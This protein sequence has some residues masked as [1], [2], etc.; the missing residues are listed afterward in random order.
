M[1]FVSAPHRLLPILSSLVLLAPAAEAKS[2]EAILQEMVRALVATMGTAEKSVPVSMAGSFEATLV[3]ESLGP[4]PIQ[5]SATYKSRP[6]AD[7]AADLTSTVGSYRVRTN[8]RQ[9]IFEATGDARYYQGEPAEQLGVT[10]SSG[11]QHKDLE[12]TLLEMLSAVRVESVS[13]VSG[14]PSGKAWKLDLRPVDPAEAAGVERFDLYVLQKSAMPWKLNAFVDG[15]TQRADVALD[16][17][18]DLPSGMR[19]KISDPEEP[20]DARFA[21]S[22]DSKGRF[23]GL[24]GDAKMGQEGTLKLKIVN[25]MS[26]KLSDADFVY[27][28]EPG[29]APATEQEITV[30]VMTRIMGLAFG[31]ALMQGF[32]P[33]K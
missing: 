29:L 28:P 9:W 25:E 13:E 10:E 14:A 7:L 12:K 8:N 30:L 21:L 20:I 4:V 33:S 11:G 2:G 24:D 3:S 17:T 18:G 27:K 22:F 31:S 6:P 1:S 26:P 32:G 15:G 23:A 16:Y 19:I 5:V